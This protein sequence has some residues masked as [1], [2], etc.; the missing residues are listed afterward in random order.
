M[1]HVRQHFARPKVSDIPK[2]VRAA[3]S[4]K[5]LAIKPGA[6]IAIT[7]GSRGISSIDVIAAAAVEFVKSAGGKPFIIPAMGSHG[8]ANP[9]GQ[10]ELL[11]SYGISERFMGAR[12]ESSMDVVEIPAPKLE[13]RVFMD[14]LAWESDGV[15]LLNRVKP[16]TDF[17]GR[18]ESGLVKMAVIGLGKQRQAEEIH[19]FGVRGIRD[20]VAPSARVVFNTGKIVGGL[21]IIE[22]AYDET[23][24]VEAF[25][26]DEI[27]DGDEELLNIARKH[28]PSL[29]VSSLDLLVGDAI[30]KDKSGT[31]M[32]TNIIGR[33]YIRGQNEPTE[34]EISSIYVADLSP[35]THGNAVGMGL[36]DVIHRRLFEK[37]DFKAS[38]AN[39]ITSSFFERGK[40]PIIADSDSDG[41]SISLRGA[42]CRDIGAARIARIRSTLDMTELLVSQAV[43]DEIAENENIEIIGEPDP[44][45]DKAGQ[46]PVLQGAH[47]GG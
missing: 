44:L 26:P 23:M 8:G 15:L 17:H 7:V 33:I 37:I 25:R 46:L 11:E 42:G 41:I 40:I 31:G 34:P 36:A 20:L 38:Y 4:E 10:A 29:P 39:I 2:A 19:S 24:A 13:N 3:L 27:L 35:A 1:Y 5:K 16:H 28:M 14:R 30:G 45:L 22:N 6:N 18:W 12:I 43:F 47:D 32:D 21:G 9:K